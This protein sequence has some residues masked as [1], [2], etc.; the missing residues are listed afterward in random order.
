M[1]VSHIMQVA[2]L[3]SSAS[4]LN[5]ETIPRMFSIAG[6]KPKGAKEEPLNSGTSISKRGITAILQWADYT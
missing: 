5:K 4:E 2:R 6:E 1:H 3:Q